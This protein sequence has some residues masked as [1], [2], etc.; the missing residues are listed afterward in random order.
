MYSFLT[1]TYISGE[2]VSRLAP[3]KHC[4]FILTQGSPDEQAFAELFAPYERFF[5]P[6][7]FGY[8]MHL[9]RGVGLSKPTDAGECEALMEQAEELGKALM[10]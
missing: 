1:P 5:G 10:E 9:L 2:N 8:H 4:V 7:W 3:G 6:D